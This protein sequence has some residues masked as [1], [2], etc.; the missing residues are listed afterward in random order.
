M[1]KLKKKRD[2]TK[3]FVACSLTWGGGGRGAGG[4][5]ESVRHK[6]ARTTEIHINLINY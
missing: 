2:K 1:V 4:G 5:G 3:K 6:S